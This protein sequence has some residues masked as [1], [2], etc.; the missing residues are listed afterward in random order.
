MEESRDLYLEN[1]E[2]LIEGCISGNRHEQNRLY[3]F[4][5]PRMLMVCLRYASSREAEE[6]LGE[7]FIRIL[8]I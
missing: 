7:G 2:E 3:G 1:L 6:A 4:F 8:P 5:A